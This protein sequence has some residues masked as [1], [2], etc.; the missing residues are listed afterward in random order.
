[1]ADCEQI[2]TDISLSNSVVESTESIIFT[3]VTGTS[4]RRTW[5]NLLAS[6][7]PSDI[8]FYV[9]SSGA[10]SDG[11]SS[12]T[13]SSLIGK[14]VRVYR[15]KVKQTTLTNGDDYRYSFNA[16]TGEITFY[17]NLSDGELVQIEP[18]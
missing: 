8:E 4:V 7:T 12:F 3:S 10:P 1:M 5:G 6:L 2:I 18:Y 17:P 11:A 15:G 16:V 9:G 13:H 14:R